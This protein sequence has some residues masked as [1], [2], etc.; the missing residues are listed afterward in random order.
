MD[1]RKLVQLIPTANW[2]ALS[3]KL[4]NLILQSKNEDKMLSKLANNILHHWQH[5]TVISESGLTVL[6]EAAFLLEPDNT[7]EAS[8]ELQLT[9]LAEKLKEIATKV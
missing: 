3:D 9:S 8:N 5:D 1:C 4:I 6:L 7:I 2:E